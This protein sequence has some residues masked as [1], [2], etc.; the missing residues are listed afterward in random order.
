MAVL[1]LLVAQCAKP[2]TTAQQHSVEPF[3]KIE[4]SS[5]GQIASPVA[6]VLRR[7]REMHNISEEVHD[8]FL[9]EQGWTKDEFQTGFRNTEAPRDGSKRFLEYEALVARE[10][11]KGNVSRSRRPRRAWRRGPLRVN[12]PVFF[13]V[14]TF[15][16]DLSRSQCSEII[17]HV[18]QRGMGRVVRITL[19]PRCRGYTPWHRK[20]VES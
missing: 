19:Y 14:R 2:A 9:Q 10:L 7:Y 1:A 16:R 11:G 3:R 5:L 8:G 18:F 15:N 12:M 6:C 4:I 20:A 17:A 13:H